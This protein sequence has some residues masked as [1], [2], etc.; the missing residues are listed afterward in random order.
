M[1]SLL[2]WSSSANSV[3]VSELNGSWKRK[4]NKLLTYM[5]SLHMKVKVKGHNPSPDH[6]GYHQFYVSSPSATS[7]ETPELN[8]S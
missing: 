7:V 3:L 4:A 2:C 8:G 1:S 5:P 6:H